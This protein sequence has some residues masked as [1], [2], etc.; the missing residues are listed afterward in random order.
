MWAPIATYS[1]RKAG[2]DPRMM[3]MTLRA[4]AGERVKPIEEKRIHRPSVPLRSASGSLPNNRVATVGET[5]KFT[6]PGVVS[7]EIV[8]A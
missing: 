1:P 8:T 6:R 5:T 7:V 4:G 3:P 2:S